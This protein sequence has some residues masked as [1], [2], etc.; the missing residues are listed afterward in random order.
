MANINCLAG[1]KCL[2]GSEGP[3]LITVCMAVEM[4]DTGCGEA[5]N[6]MTFDNDSRCVCRRC[7][8]MGVVGDFRRVSAEE[9]LLQS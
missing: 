6:D 3:F 4:Y 1:M 2:C 5:F 7:D 9:A 8:R